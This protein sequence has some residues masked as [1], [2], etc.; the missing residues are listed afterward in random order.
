MEFSGS[1]WIWGLSL[2]LIFSDSRNRCCSY[3]HTIIYILFANVY[4]Y[5][6]IQETL[7]VWTQCGVIW[8]K[9]TTCGIRTRSRGANLLHS[10]GVIVQDDDAVYLYGSYHV[11]GGI[12]IR[13]TITWLHM[14]G[15]YMVQCISITLCAF[16]GRS[17]V[18]WNFDNIYS[19]IA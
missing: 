13:V 19:N 10:W 16:A 2:I 3:D 8:L 11:C 5:I 4:T 1:I 14:W 15:P 17:G 7:R 12:I 9:A 6:Y 18:I